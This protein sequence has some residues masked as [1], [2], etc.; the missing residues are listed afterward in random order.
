MRCALAG[1]LS[2]LFWASV[3][4]LLRQ[5]SPYMSISSG[6]SWSQEGLECGEGG[7]ER[8]TLLRSL[9]RVLQEGVVSLK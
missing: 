4:R 9:P 8:G 7:A 2:S 3:L 6:T 5:P 1:Y